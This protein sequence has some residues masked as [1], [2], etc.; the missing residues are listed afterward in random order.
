[1]KLSLIAG[2]TVA[3]VSGSSRASAQMSE[4]PGLV[5]ASA[6]AAAAV[7]A[8]K[9]TI[10]SPTSETINEEDDEAVHVALRGTLAGED[11]WDA[12]KHST[13]GKKFTPEKVALEMGAWSYKAGIIA[14][15]HDNLIMK[16]NKGS[17]SVTGMKMSMIHKWFGKGQGPPGVGRW[18]NDAFNNALSG[19]VTAGDLVMD[20]NENYKLPVKKA[21]PK[22]QAWSYKAGIIETI[23]E[24]NGR[25]SSDADIKKYMIGKWFEKKGKGPE[26]FI[27]WS[28]DAFKNALSGAVTSGDL[29]MD[30]NENYKLKPKVEEELITI[31]G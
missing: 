7:V 14:I 2:L 23:V 15:F 26:G 22:K 17:L 20:D 11:G 30:A 18:S 19:V 25:P 27:R 12:S 9:D 4:V 24:F 5:S 28:D 6:S 21:A 3:L 8:D 16:Y 13:E 10:T 31:K 29:V 1:M